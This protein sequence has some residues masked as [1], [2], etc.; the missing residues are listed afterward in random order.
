MNHCAV[1][2][3]AFQTLLSH[4]RSIVG[5]RDRS[6]LDQALLLA[7]RAILAVEHG[8]M[9]RVW[10]Y[11]GRTILSP[12]AAMSGDQLKTLPISH[13]PINGKSL[14]DV[15][16]YQRSCDTDKIIRLF[17]RGRHRHIVP[18]FRYGKAYAILELDRASP[19]DTKEIELTNLL[20]GLFADH[21]NLLDY[22]ETDTLT[23]LPNRKTF[24]ENLVQILANTQTENDSGSTELSS[25]GPNRRDSEKQLTRS[26]LAVADIDHFK[27]IN[28]THGHIIGDEVLILVARLLRHAFRFGDQLFRFGGEEFVIVLQ[29][30]TQDDA[31]AVV[32]RF[33]AA[34]EQQE[35]PLIGNLTISIGVTHIDAMDTPTELVGRADQALYI[36]KSEGRNRVMSYEQLHDAGWFCELGVEKP[37][38]EIF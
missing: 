18:I 26:W 14:S 32:E 35:F 10:H 36:A 27:Q 25:T 8:Q 31:L 5:Q 37:Q 6:G 23:G 34:V 12:V 2:Q 13:D 38:A 16:E 30:T 7:T 20:L 19:F 29:P 22:A 28:D 17:E 3:Q 1:T 33:R 21:L 15:P 24:D 11:K 4:L 9:F